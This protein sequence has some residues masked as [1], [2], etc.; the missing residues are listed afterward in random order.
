MAISRRKVLA[1]M[2]VGAG[3]AVVGQGG[4]SA[5][6]DAQPSGAGGGEASL[7]PAAI[8]PGLDYLL[9]GGSEFMGRTNDIA[10]SSGTTGVYTTTAG[11]FIDSHFGLP[12]GATLKE[13]EIFASGTGSLDIAIYRVS[14]AVAV[15]GI[16]TGSATAAAPGTLTFTEVTDGNSIY[17]IE[18]DNTSATLRFQT[19]RIGFIPPYRRLVTVSPQVRAYNT[20][21]TAGLVK[22]ANTEERVIDLS[23]VVPAGAVAAV[24]NL[25][26]TQQEGPGFLGLFP[27]GTAWPNT[28][29]INYFTGQDIAN[30]SIVGVS[31]DRK[32]KAH[33]GGGATHV[34]VDVTGYLI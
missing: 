21:D 15:T 10:F 9:L 13:I 19:A 31:A 27:D 24:L 30:N 14:T 23:A 25:T 18:I 33:C 20:R 22:F 32:I 7:V 3:A 5:A 26:T 1:G 4:A 11:A 17:V 29:S 16:G 34:I 2:G 12:V 6:P 8:T 28:S